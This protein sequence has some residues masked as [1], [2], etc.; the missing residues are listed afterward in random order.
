MTLPLRNFQLH[1]R[2]GQPACFGGQGT[3]PNEQNTQQSPLS[4]RNRAPHRAQSKTN[5]QALSGISSR[6]VQPQCGQVT[7]EWRMTPRMVVAS[8]R[9]V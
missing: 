6:C 9:L 3:E 2:M 4:G 8:A 5:R 7:T 1:L